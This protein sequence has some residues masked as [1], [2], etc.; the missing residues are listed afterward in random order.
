MFLITLEWAEPTSKDGPNQRRTG[1]T[2]L[3]E[4]AQRTL[5]ELLESVLPGVA[6]VRTPW[7]LC[8]ADA[9]GKTEQSQPQGGSTNREDS[10]GLTGAYK[11]LTSDLEREMK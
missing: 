8:K 4:E 7:M 9:T 6:K 5:L 2:R 11:Y 1:L 10:R 3:G